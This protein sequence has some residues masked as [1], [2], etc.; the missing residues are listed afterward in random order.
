MGDYTDFAKAAR[1]EAD[2]RAS[3]HASIIGSE[4]EQVLVRRA[5]FTG[6]MRGVA[7][8][9]DRLAT[10]EPSEA[11]VLAV[12]KAIQGDGVYPNRPWNSLL[13]AQQASHCRTARR[14]IVASRR[15]QSEE[16]QWE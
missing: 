13:P 11:E 5:T 7:W 16:M 10:Q 6:V 12:A 2:E 8:L 14:A 15:V 4:K 9:R 3:A 1:A